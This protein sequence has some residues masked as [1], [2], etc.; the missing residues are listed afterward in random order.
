MFTSKDRNLKFL[1]V[2]AGACGGQENVQWISFDILGFHY[3]FGC[4]EH[5]PG[6][7]ND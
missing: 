7:T 5:K 3:G 2:T 1:K 4:Y 6:K